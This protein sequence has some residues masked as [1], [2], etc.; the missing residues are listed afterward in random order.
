MTNRNK[1]VLPEEE[2][3]KGRRTGDLLS[4]NSKAVM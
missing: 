1:C 4:Y 2:K 3:I